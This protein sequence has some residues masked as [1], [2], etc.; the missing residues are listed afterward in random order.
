[1]RWT[2][3][4]AILALAL[5]F[6]LP[7]DVESQRAQ[8][9]SDDVREYVS[10]DA[11][12]IALVGVTVVDGT[13][14]QPAE[15]QTVLIRDGRIEAVGAAASV[16]V[17]DGAQIHELPGHTVIPGLIGMHNH[18]F[19]T[20]SGRSV[21]LDYSAPRLYLGSGVT[22]IRTTGAA[23][24]YSEINMMRGIDDGRIP[25]PRMHITGPY[26]TGPGAGGHMLTVD[27]EEEARRVVA[28]WAEEGATWFKAYTRISNDALG[29][30]I[31]EA[32]SRGLKFTGHLCSV[33]YREAV[34]LGIDNLEHGLF[35]NSD[36]SEREPDE[37]PSS[38][39]SDLVEID[40]DSEEVQATI[41]DMVD[42]GVGMT[43]TL[44]VYELTVPGRPPLED[45]F[46]EIL[47]PEA[48]QEY[49]AT[50]QRI[51]ENADQSIMPQVF[52]KS[53]EFEVAFVRAGGLLA[54]GVDPTGNGGALPG[55][56]DQRNH[57]LLIEAGFTPV[58]SIQILTLNGARILGNDDELGSVEQGKVADLAV[59]AGNPVERPEEIRNVVTV[60][61]DGIGYDAE[62][63]IQATRGIMGV[64]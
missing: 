18:T 5:A 35:T 34:A 61:K 42:N 11:P 27:S 29:A 17:P 45:R 44:A 52:Q 6:L 30:A 46:E 12:V 48:F 59:I 63:L 56:G 58:E 7:G 49:L 26:I 3:T 38:L 10:T 62:A 15:D 47:A 41:R 9:L 28:Y 2:H 51:Q 43:S 21:Q 31:Q 50:R 53:Q 8:H 14:A 60:F 25:G 23:S 33:S 24:P 32:H 20:T 22:T 16:E 64:R 13:G 54:A 55:F 37:C 19:Y 39:R 1:M 36:Y 57:E 4:P 40:L